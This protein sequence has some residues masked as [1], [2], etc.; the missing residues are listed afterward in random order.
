VLNEQTDALLAGGKI[1]P[2]SSPAGL[3]VM[4]GKRADGMLHLVGD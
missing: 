2:H 4:F 3:P 1:Y